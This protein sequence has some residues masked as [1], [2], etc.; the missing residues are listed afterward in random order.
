MTIESP[1]GSASSEVSFLQGEQKRKELRGVSSG[2]KVSVLCVLLCPEDKVISSNIFFL[3]S[4]GNCL[5]LLP[6][7]KFNL[8]EEAT[9]FC[10]KYFLDTRPHSLSPGAVLGFFLHWLNKSS[11]SN[12]GGI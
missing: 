8:I 6:L 3:N 5:F 10:K 2:V 1:S 12:A 7:R 11:L 4:R 9:A